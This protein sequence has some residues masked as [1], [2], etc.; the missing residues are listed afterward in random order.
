MRELKPR[1]NWYDSISES[2][3]E[4]LFKNWPNPLSKISFGY[5]RQNKK[6]FNSSLFTSRSFLFLFF[7]L[8]LCSAGWTS[9][10]K[11]HQQHK[12]AQIF[13]KETSLLAEA[14]QD[15]VD[16]L[17]CF[18]D[19]A[20]LF[21]TCNGSRLSG[22]PS[23]DRVV[24]WLRAGGHPTRAYQSGRLCLTRRWAERSEVSPS[25]RSGPETTRARNSAGTVQL[26]RQLT[27]QQLI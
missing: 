12:R 21:G 6:Y 10:T 26:A 20:A 5:L 8:L 3:F 18:V 15:G 27:R 9:K 1:M 25:G 22:S 11:C 14:S 19:F 16:V 24:D 2:V 7:C 23:I 4:P 13:T 17:E